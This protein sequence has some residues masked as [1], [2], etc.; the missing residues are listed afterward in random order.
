MEM[1]LSDHAK[2]WQ[3]QGKGPPRGTDEWREMY[4]TWVNWAFADLHD[5][6]DSTR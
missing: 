1:K 4:E 2:W 3:E 6:T 5:D